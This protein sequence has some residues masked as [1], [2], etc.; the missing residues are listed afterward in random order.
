MAEFVG[1]FVGHVRIAKEQLLGA[2]REHDQRG[3]T[4]VLLN[5][6]AFRYGGRIFELRKAGWDIETKQESE[7]VFRFTQ[8]N[9][10]HCKENSL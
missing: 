7:G 3:C 9:R 4:N 2:R 8:R 1:T 6:I 10:R 5:E